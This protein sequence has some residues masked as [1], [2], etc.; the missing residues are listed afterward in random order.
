MQRRRSESFHLDVSVICTWTWSQAVTSLHIRESS[1]GVECQPLWLFCRHKATQ[2]ISQRE[3]FHGSQINLATCWTSLTVW[4]T[5][6]NKTKP[7]VSVRNNKLVLSQPDWRHSEE[8]KRT[9]LI[10]LFSIATHHHHNTKKMK[11]GGG[12]KKALETLCGSSL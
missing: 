11:G 6:A 5:L 12:R 8:R 2:L 4:L 3:H 7:A 1:N 10:C 9:I